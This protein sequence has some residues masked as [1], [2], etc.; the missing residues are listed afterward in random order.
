MKFTFVSPFSATAR[1][2]AVAAVCGCMTMTGCTRLNTYDERI[3]PIPLPALQSDHVE[4]QGAAFAAQSYG[5]PEQSERAF[6]FDIHSAGIMPVRFVIDNRGREVVHVIPQQTFLIDL[7]DQAWPLLTAEQAT[8]RI[9][10]SVSLGET[11][12]RVVED[13]LGGGALGAATGFAVAL[14]TGNGLAANF[15]Y[16]LRSA[17]AGAAYNVM[18]GLPA[19]TSNQDHRIR[20]DVLSHSMRKKQLQPGELAHGFLFFPG[21]QEARTA[22]ELR[23]GLEFDGYPK[24]ITVPVLPARLPAASAP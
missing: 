5:D 3:A 14:V 6:G 21:K 10:E 11:A 4:A 19:E 23:L 18:A 8:R 15:D 12:R 9:R 17:E 22:K 20:K 16:V 7:D 2:T 13:F 24:V 1:W